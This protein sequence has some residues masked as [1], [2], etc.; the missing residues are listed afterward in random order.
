MDTAPRVVPL[1]GPD[2]D[3]LENQAHF[4]CP[5]FSALPLLGVEIDVLSKE[6]GAGRSECR[7]E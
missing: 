6:E 4:C 1:A 3:L 5:L 7:T 2:L